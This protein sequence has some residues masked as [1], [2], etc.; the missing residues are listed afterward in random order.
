M[1]VLLL[2]VAGLFIR[3]AKNATSIDPGFDPT[4]VVVGSLDLETRGYSEARG[5]EF[6]RTLHDRLN[7][8]GGLAAATLVDIVPVTL[9]NQ[10][11][12]LLHESDP[13]P[14]RG[15]R[16]PRPRAYTN[17]VGPGHFRTLRIGLVAGRDFT[18]A[19]TRDRAAGRDRQRDLRQAVLAGRVRR[20][21]PAQAARRRPIPRRIIEVVGVVRDSKYVTVGEEDRAVRLSAAR[22]VVHPARHRHRPIE[23]H[24]GRGHRPDQERAARAGR[25][26]GALRG[27]DADGRDVGVAAA[28]AD[29]R[30][31]CWRRSADWR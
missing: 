23:H 13:E 8:A 29:G 19:D 31:D 25:G 21:T 27:L 2:V 10:T 3:S 1:S 16:S 4:N 28:G 9:S 15:E 6:L 26:P 22:A 18:H 24:D 5:Q 7:A 11:I 12:D 20:R 30:N 14:A 17:N